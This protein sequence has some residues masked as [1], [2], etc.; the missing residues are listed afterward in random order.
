MINWW[1]SI[2]W[3]IGLWT[4]GR[5]AGEFIRYCWFKGKGKIDLKNKTEQLK[6]YKEYYDARKSY[7]DIHGTQK[8]YNLPE[9][10]R[11]EKA[12]KAIA[13]MRKKI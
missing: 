1:D 8:E 10:Y 4:I 9:W 2:F 11:I 7:F 5:W 6:I 3:V 12:D 13:D